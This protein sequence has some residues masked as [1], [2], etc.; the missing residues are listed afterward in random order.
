MAV[1]PP[2]FPTPISGVGAIKREEHVKLPDI[3]TMMIHNGIFIEPRFMSPFSEEHH[4]SVKPVVQSNVNVAKKGKRSQ[5]KLFSEAQRSILLSWLR[6][7]SQNPYPSAA[8]KQVLMDKT[9]LNKEQ[10]NVWFTNTRV[11]H[12]MSSYGNKT[13]S[14]NCIRSRRI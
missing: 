1:I 13:R 4:L 9:G 11:R 6:E 8:E 10:I 12:G 5:R 14:S 7:N 2:Q 3:Y